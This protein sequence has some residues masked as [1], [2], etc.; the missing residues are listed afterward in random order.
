MHRI[1]LRRHFL[2]PLGD[3][4]QVPV[5]ST[6]ASLSSECLAFPFA[7]VR[8]VS[9]GVNETSST[10]RSRSSAITVASLSILRFLFVGL[11][12]GVGMS[13]SL[14]VSESAPSAGR[15]RGSLHKVF[16]H[17][18]RRESSN[19]RAASSAPAV[20]NFPRAAYSFQSPLKST[21]LIDGDG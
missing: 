10:A 4:R 5:L 1:F 21:V 3:E 2:T 19:S 8:T 17:V 6:L 9:V 7:L 15:L 16:G 12:I 18:P 20:F 14:L 11:S 13:R